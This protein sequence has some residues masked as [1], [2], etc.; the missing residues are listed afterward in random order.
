MGLVSVFPVWLGQSIDTLPPMYMFMPD[1]PDP[2]IDATSS[3]WWVAH[4]VFSC[5]DAG[6][7][8]IVRYRIDTRQVWS[9]TIRDS[10][11]ILR[12]RFGELELGG[13]IDS[14]IAQLGRANREQQVAPVVREHRWRRG[15]VT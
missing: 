10:T 9:I 4:R 11:S 12:A 6:V 8:V 1:A 5:K 2:M 3:L 15:T 7:G 14:I 13:D